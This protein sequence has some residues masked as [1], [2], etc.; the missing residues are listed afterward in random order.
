MPHPPL[1]N[2]FEKD[3]QFAGVTFVVTSY[4]T[5]AALCKFCS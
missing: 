2:L 4:L 1:T 5:N 3:L